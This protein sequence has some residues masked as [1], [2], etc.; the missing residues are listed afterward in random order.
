MLAQEDEVDR[1]CQGRLTLFNARAR[2]DLTFPRNS[3]RTGHFVVRSRMS[4]RWS[5]LDSAQNKCGRN[6]KQGRRQGRVARGVWPNGGREEEWAVDEYK[7][8]RASFSRP[9]GQT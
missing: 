1:P 3:K 4:L 7:R 6:R 8:G 2:S 5:V 9:H